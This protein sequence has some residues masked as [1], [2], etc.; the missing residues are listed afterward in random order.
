LLN[1]HIIVKI[2][3]MR[4]CNC[5][6]HLALKIGDPGEPVWEDRS[7]NTYCFYCYRKRPKPIVY[8]ALCN[9]CNKH[10]VISTQHTRCYYHDNRA[11]FPGK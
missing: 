1:T 3:A 8:V 10:P 11:L 5:S 2:I 9:F 4:C 6:V 7:G